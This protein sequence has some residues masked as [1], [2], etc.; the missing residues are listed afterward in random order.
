M[1]DQDEQQIRALCDHV[2]GAIRARNLD[3]MMTAYADDVIQFDATGALAQRGAEQVRESTHKWFAGW[4]GR[5]DFEV[6]E[7]TIDTSGD[8]AFARS[9]NRSAGTAKQGAH[10]EMWVRWTAC[11][12]KLDGTWKVVHEHVSVPFDPKTMKP[13]LALEPPARRG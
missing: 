12:R 5:I 9:F 6:R 1:S 8:L 3:Q 10:V 4:E 11:F 13:E 2:A 7:L